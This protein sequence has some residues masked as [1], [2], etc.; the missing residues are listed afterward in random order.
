MPNDYLPKRDT[1]LSLWL[2]NFI[3]VA[4]ANITLLAFLPADLMNLSND[5]ATFTGNVSQLNAAKETLK[6]AT[7]NKNVARKKAVADARALARRVQSNAAVTPGL[8]SLLGLN[9]KTNKPGVVQPVTPTDLVADGYSNGVNELKWNRNG[10]HPSTVFLV[11]AQIGTATE[12][13]QI[14][15]VTAAKFTHS[16]VTPG[17]KVVYRVRARRRNVVSDP[18]NFATLYGATIESLNTWWTLLNTKKKIV[19]YKSLFAYFAFF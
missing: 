10:N 13:T 11:E 15:A 17:M 19:L 1:E 3:T 8:K 7:Q 5:N 18:S 9:P 6:S 2:G 4:Q 16:G 12:F 14:G